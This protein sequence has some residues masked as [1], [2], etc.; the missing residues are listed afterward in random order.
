MCFDVDHC[1][2]YVLMCISFSS[3]IF[4]ASCYV[5]G[6]CNALLIFHMP[7]IIGVHRVTWICF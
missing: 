2:Q 3:T 1:L 5:A 4:D 6:S 7:L